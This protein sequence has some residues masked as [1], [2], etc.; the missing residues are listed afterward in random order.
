MKTSLFRG[1]TLTFVAVAFAALSLNAQD[2]SAPPK[3]ERQREKGLPQISVIDKLLSVEAALAPVLGKTTEDQWAGD[4][5]SLYDQFMRDVAIN[6]L[7]GKGD[8]EVVDALALGIKA[9]DAVLALKARNIE[10][11]NLAAEQIEALAT[12]LG[13]SKGELRMADTVKRYANDRRWLDAFL[14][15]GYLQRSVLNYLRE[16][17][18]K[19]P[20][21]VLVIVG[22]WLQGGRCVTHV[23]K[24]NYAK[25]HQQVHVS[26]ILREPR[27]VGMLKEEM[28]QLPPE[29][30]NNVLVAKILG[31]LPQIKERV[32]VS[33]Y[34]PV[35]EEDVD[36]LHKTFDDVVT[37]IAPL[38]AKA[39]AA[40]PAK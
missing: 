13:A 18:E 39:G 27:L 3:S 26:N 10:A 17:P 14:A 28:D 23:V 19:K 9:S 12:R 24:E 5:Q 25:D 37:Q 34:A 40:A 1:C 22:G 35:K 29:Y 36:W 21:A 4:Y 15:L 2:G 32:N 7:P 30:L 11:L 31:L 20:Q 16:N 38:P 33:L 8:D 6:S